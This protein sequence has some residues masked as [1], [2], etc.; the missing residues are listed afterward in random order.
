MINPSLQSNSQKPS[1]DHQSPAIVQDIFIKGAREH[2]LKNIDVSIPAERLIVVTGVSG[3]GKS[4]LIIDTLFAEGQRRYVESLSSYARQFLMRMDKPDVDYIN[5]ILPAIAIEQKVSTRTSRSTVG[6]LTEIYDYLRLLYAR[7][8]KTYSP[9]SGQEV[10]RHSTGDVVQFIQDQKPG[11]KVMITFALDEQDMRN[12]RLALEVLMQKGYTR[13]VVED[14]LEE[15]EDVLDRKIQE[16]GSRVLVL[17]DRIVTNPADSEQRKRIADSVHA[18]FSDGR[19]SCTVNIIGQG[20]YTFSN[21]LEL[22]G[23]RFD[24]PNEH[25]FSYNNPYGACPKCEGFGSVIG[26]DPDR[27]IPDKRLSVF[28]NAIACWRGEKMK[29]WKEALIRNASHFGFPIHRPI[30][31]LTK[32]QYDLLWTGNEYF[33]G[34]ND[35]FRMV[36]ENSYKIQYRV[37]L[38][39]YRGKTVCD[40]CRGTRLRKEA[41]YVKIAG[42]DITQLADMQVID[43]LSFFRQL[44]LPE[45]EKTVSN[46]IIREITNRLQF[47]VDVGLEY[48]TLDRLSNTLSGGETQR[49]NLT[50]T[51][52]SNLTSSLYILDEPSIGLHPRD[53]SRLI[54]SLKKLRDLGNT[55]IVIEHDVEIM[56]AADY[57]I[58]MGPE[59]GT[60]GGEVV[61]CGTLEEICHGGKSLTAKYLNGDLKI[62][63]PESRR[64]VTNR[65]HFKGIHLHNLNGIDVSIPLDVLTVV[66][67]VSGSGKSTLVKDVLYPAMKEWLET[68]NTSG[69]HFDSLEG[70][71]SR[72]A[73]VEMIDQNPIGRSSR[74]NPVT[75]LKAWDLIREIFASRPMARVRGFKPKHFSFNVE[76][77]RCETCKGEGENVIEMQ[78][79][80][81]VHLVCEDCGGKRFKPE[82]L[83]VTYKGKNIH[84]ILEMTVD[85]AIAFFSDH[86]ELIRRLKPLADVGLGYIHLGQSSSTLS[87]GEAQRVKL[88]SYLG[89]ANSREPFLFLFDEPTTG[90]HFH[91]IKKLLAAFDALIEAGH[92]IVVIE[93]N[94]D[95][96][97][98][99][100]W[101]ID[102][103]PEG[104][105]KGGN[106]VFSGTPEELLL[107]RES[108][109]GRYLQPHFS[110][111]F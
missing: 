58:D 8:G 15:I 40:A 13:I 95:I 108:Y 61:D 111:S 99:A 86:A 102:L 77:G 81:D 75:Y 88:A 23:M 78:F 101:I 14:R 74:S 80:A 41:T 109:T 43:L 92:S 17:V 94:P 26:I 56:A 82:V 34:I 11:T 33:K 7:I 54:K 67:G 27:V 84:D 49:I 18:A 48:L 16:P 65:L 91:D 35:F 47:M 45:H 50:R 64:Q 28:E 19:G 31:E 12:P 73:R 71:L 60:H 107:C 104:G 30:R 20:L 110:K 98:S 100:D 79:L 66:T 44:D 10:K 59:A 68:Q 38:S 57:L 32:E 63:V 52:G 70:D 69:K 51:L 85:E 55:V 72:I 2:N 62:P 37:L 5:G 96:I 53:T 46:R 93:H 3:S 83:E 103:G 39:R 25:L 1:Q 21:K 106:I 24:E 97:K 6:T 29:K 4:S 87:G 105:E 36:E 9:V 76:G 89:H 22:D 42:H 90:L